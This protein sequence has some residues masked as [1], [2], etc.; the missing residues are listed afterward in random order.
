MTTTVNAYYSNFYLL[1]YSKKVA[2]STAITALLLLMAL[3]LQ[4]YSNKSEF[5]DL[6]RMVAFPLFAFVNALTIW[7]GMQA[8]RLNKAYAPPLFK[9][10]MC[11]LLTWACFLIVRS[12][13]TSLTLMRDLLATHWGAMS[14]LFP[15]LAFCGMRASFWVNFCRH[16]RKFLLFGIA[17]VGL[18]LF[19]LIIGVDDSF[20]FVSHQILF[21]APL[22]FLSGFILGKRFIYLGTIGLFIWLLYAFFVDSRE[23]IFLILWYFFCAIFASRNSILSSK[24]KLRYLFICLCASVV[25]IFSGNQLYETI[26]TESLNTRVREF[27]IEGGA[28]T[29]SRQGLV[30]GFFRY[31]TL[32]DIIFGKGA[33]AS[34]RIDDPRLSQSFLKEKARQHI[35]IGHLYHTLTG[36]IVQNLLFYSIALGSIFLGLRRSRNRFTNFL[37]FII[38]GWFLLM[39]TA[40]TP[41][42]NLRYLLVWLAIGGCWSSE[43]RSLTTTQFVSLWFHPDAI[44]SEAGLPQNHNHS[45]VLASCQ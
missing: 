14:C 19:L 10:L 40:A 22:F 16:G 8:W 30:A 5:E 9:H 32:N 26:S 17:I 27:F 7:L 6:R 15:L 11:L 25:L 21:M 1:A 12:F 42:G 39:F 3:S 20:V 34:Y 29:D 13:D 36:G 28:L 23:N 35:E 37:A 31:L 4:A 2:K 33:V 44:N 45:Q 24:D 41:F 43:M 38:L 18:K